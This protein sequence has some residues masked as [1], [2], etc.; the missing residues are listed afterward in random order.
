MRLLVTAGFLQ[1]YVMD[2][3][4]NI[5]E[6]NLATYNKIADI[7]RSW[8]IPAVRRYGQ[9]RPHP[10]P[11]TIGDNPEAAK[12]ARNTLDWSACDPTRA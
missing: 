4:R 1:L 11:P 8:P 12:Y 6:V 2:P 9:S 7:V 5:I 3:D 10:G